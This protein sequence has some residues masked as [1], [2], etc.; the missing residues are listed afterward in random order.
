MFYIIITIA[1]GA[2]VNVVNIV[3]VVVVVVVIVVCVSS[4]S[5]NSNSGRRD[6]GSSNSSR[7]TTTTTTITNT[8]SISSSSNL[9]CIALV[10]YCI[11]RLLM[12]FAKSTS[13]FDTKLYNTVIL[14]T[15]SS[16]VF[17]D[18]LH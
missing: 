15:S 17:T 10:T 8:T 4:S 9:L 2:V 7:D 16:M 3:V 11:P 5:S 12:R 14:S 18:L 13:D 1:K 6:T